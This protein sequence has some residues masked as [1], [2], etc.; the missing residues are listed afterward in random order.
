MANNEVNAGFVIFRNPDGAILFETDNR[1]PSK[2]TLPGGGV[3]FA[4]LPID[5]VPREVHEE[6]GVTISRQRLTIVGCFV[7][8]LTYGD[9][10]LFEYNGVRRMHEETFTPDPSE[11]TDIRWL[12]PEEVASLPSDEIYDA[13]KHLV[14]HYL[15]WVNSGRSGFVFDFLSPP[16][17]TC[18]S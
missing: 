13:Q 10:F 9:V 3:G 16:F 12:K 1:T 7:R 5:S 11:V 14:M 15:N 18:R 2:L 4:E 6:L 8:R 17:L